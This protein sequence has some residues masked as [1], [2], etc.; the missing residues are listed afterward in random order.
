VKQ[1]AQGEVMTERERQRRD[2]ELFYLV[3]AI[4]MAG[5]FPALFLIL[6]ICDWVRGW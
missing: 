5:F 3:G 2:S 1:K 4:C 6:F